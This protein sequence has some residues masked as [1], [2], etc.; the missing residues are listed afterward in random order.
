[1]LLPGRARTAIGFRHGRCSSSTADGRRRRE[2]GL[3]AGVLVASLLGAALLPAL[4]TSAGAL[5]ASLGGGAFTTRLVVEDQGLGTVSKYLFGANLLWADDAEG[6]FDPASGTFY[7]GFVSVLKGLGVS[8][9]RYPGGTTSDSFDWERAIG[10]QAVRRPNEPYGTQAAE[11]SGVL[12]GPQPSTVGPDEFGRLLD[13]TGAAGTVTVNFATGTAQEAADFVAYMTAPSSAHPSANPAEPTYW[14]ALRARNGHPA[15]YDVPYWEVGNEQFSPAQYGWRSGRPVT[16]GAH[17]VPCPPGEVATCLYAFGG[18]TAFSDEAVGTFADDQPPA[19]FSTGAPDQRFYVYFPPVVPAS[20]TVYVDGRPWAEVGDLSK[21]ATGAQVY[22]LDPASGAISFGDG[23]HGE[24]PPKGAKVT[25]SYESGPH[26]GFVQFYRAMKAMNPNISVCESEGSNTSFLALMGHTYPYDCVVLHEYARPADVLAPLDQYEEDLM[27]FPVAEGAQLEALQDAARQYS[28]RQV[29]VYL[30][31]YGQLVAPVPAADPEF[32]LS[33]DEGLLIGAQLSEWAEHGVQVAEKYLADSEPFGASGVMTAESSGQ[34]PLEASLAY[35]RE[36]VEAGLSV[37]SA[38]VAHEEGDFVAEPTGEALGLMAQMAGAQLL[39]VSVVGGP[40]MG[41][42]TRP[43]PALWATA[44]RKNDSLYL[45]VVNADPTVAVRTVVVL[46]AFGHSPQL[47]ATVL[48]GASPEA[49][50]SVAQPDE[51]TTTCTT[52]HVA[53]GD[54]TWT[55]P[56]HSLS[57]LEVPLEGGARLAPR[58]VLALR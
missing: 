27:A 30:T 2:T 22:E 34:T 11:L 21:A 41:C 50:N 12:D 5:G 6:A 54:F 43:A 49:S 57:L 28:G 39:P 4:A 20:A 7:P 31:E 32:N 58:T 53:K 13:Q 35:D 8:I 37:D 14:A 23:T 33:L 9:L 15:P 56:A 47:A 18:T 26:E 38:M 52:H 10:P 25:A 44:G 16:L 29:P 48:D 17:A 40:V 3:P 42:G 55:F 36:M 19:S 45:A 51:V 46:D 1:M 24:I